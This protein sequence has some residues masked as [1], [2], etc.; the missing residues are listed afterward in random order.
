MN[1]GE[2][3]KSITLELTF[4]NDEDYFKFMDDW[5]CSEGDVRIPS[6]CK[7][8]AKTSP[9]SETGSEQAIWVHWDENDDYE[10]WGETQCCESWEDAVEYM[11]KQGKKKYEVEVE[12]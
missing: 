9:K 4:K 7:I 1:E 11:K 2:R 10:C 8:K 5:G 12:E 3:M 6:N